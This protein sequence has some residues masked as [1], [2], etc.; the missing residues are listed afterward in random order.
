MTR[1]TYTPV[2]A[3][4][5][6]RAALSPA[7]LDRARRL[8]AELAQTLSDTTAAATISSAPNTDTNRLLAVDEARQMLGIS[9]W[10]L[11][12]LIREHRL[13][14]VKIGAR[15]FVPADALQ[16]FVATL[17]THGDAL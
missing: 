9:K 16:H 8:L 7:Q 15:R 13:D 1:S 11:Y 6:R 10:T 2:P 3:E 4:P 17:R 14:T 5:S 12:R